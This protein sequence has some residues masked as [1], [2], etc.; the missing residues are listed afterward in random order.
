MGDMKNEHHDATD[1]LLQLATTALASGDG[2]GLR[3]VVGLLGDRLPP[4][5]WRLADSVVKY[6]EDGDEETARQIWLHCVDA[7]GSGPHQRPSRRTGLSP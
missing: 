1:N 6:L 3:S 7:A 2:D 5:L 4:R